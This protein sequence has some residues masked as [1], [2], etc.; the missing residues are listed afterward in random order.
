LRAHHFART[1][2][3]SMIRVR[4]IGGKGAASWGWTAAVAV[5][6]VLGGANWTMPL[7]RFLAEL[8]GVGL[9]IA[10]IAAPPAQGRLQMTVP[11]WLWLCLF[12]L[13]AFHL[14]PLPPSIWTQLPGR[15]LAELADRA[16]FGATG[17]RPLSLDPEATWRSLL[18]LLPAFATYLAVRLGDEARLAAL[19][20]GVAIAA[21]VAIA[22]A[23]LQ[24]ALPGEALL[25]FYP[26]GDYEQPVGFFT[27]RNHQ[28]SFLVCA[29]PLIAA[30][31]LP[32]PA[33]RRD[34]GSWKSAGLLLAAYAALASLAVLSTA[35]RAGAALL[36]LGFAATAFAWLAAW[37]HQGR[38]APVPSR[39]QQGRSWRILAAV[40]ALVIAGAVAIVI[41]ATLGGD[42]IAKV[43]K[44]APIAHDQRFDYWP[45]VADAAAQFWPVGS[46]IGTFLSGY[47]M[48][49]PLEAVG[50][51][52]LNHA[53]NDFLEIVLEAGVPALVLA[54]AGIWELSVIAAKAWRAEPQ[55]T[56]SATP[57][58]LAS[59]ALAVPILHSLF[60]YPLRTVAITCLFALA[61]GMLAVAQLNAQAEARPRL[62]QGAGLPVE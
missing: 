48:H 44:R 23:M 38:A 11:D 9:L 20:R 52:Y 55:A 8:V 56:L 62:R 43:L 45:L 24:M 5:I 30:L 60:D 32:A 46:G 14:I 4:H 3:G 15:E 29:L 37:Q 2:S 42:D 54:L 33:D 19:L 59:I 16:V 28:A 7:S 35:S 13:F 53:H 57:A 27:N 6:L 58:R 31:L 47:E 41:V 50:P 34:S 25:H 49:E 18:M 17:W 26:R 22:I 51:L 12:A 36:I 21:L 1:S 39:L 10:A 61:A 40:G